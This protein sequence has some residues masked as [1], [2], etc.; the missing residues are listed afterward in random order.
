ME[1]LADKAEREV[2]NAMRVWFMR[3]KLG[4]EF[5]GSIVRVSPYGVKVRLKDFFVEGI[6]HVS[7]MTDDFY[8]FNERTMSLIGRNTKRAAAAGLPRSSSQEWILT[9]WPTPRVSTS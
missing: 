4:E 6:L 8:Q 7:F 1:R 5:S 2:V 3:D 9:R